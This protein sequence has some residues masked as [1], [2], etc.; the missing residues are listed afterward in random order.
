M[1]GKI[2][3]TSF[4]ESL[5]IFGKWSEI[6]RKLS[7]LLSSVCLYNKKNIKCLLNDMNFMF[8]WRE[9][10]LIRSLC[11]FVRHHSCHSNTKFFFV[12]PPCK[13]SVYHRI[14]R[15]Q[16]LKPAS[17]GTSLTNLHKY[18]DLFLKTNN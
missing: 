6:F 13:S 16:N 2:C 8:M 17:C 3:V 5:E 9:Q 12:S 1:F 10:H 14:T 4:G 18:T 15:K 11:S 7:K